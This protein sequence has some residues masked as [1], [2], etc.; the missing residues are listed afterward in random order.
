MLFS[1]PHLIIAVNGLHPTKS[2]AKIMIG[3]NRDDRMP[4]PQVRRQYCTRLDAR[5]PAT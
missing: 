5:I 3:D 1:L 2:A 4:A